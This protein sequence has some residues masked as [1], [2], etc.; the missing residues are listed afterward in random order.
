M[1]K[2]KARAD[3]T[4]LEY[5]YG[6]T[7]AFIVKYEEATYEKWHFHDF[8]EIQY[9]S[10]GHGF[11]LIGD[12]KIEVKAGDVFLT[13]FG[14]NH[15]FVSCDAREPL[16]LTNC[17]FRRE[18]FEELPLNLEDFTELG[19]DI[20]YTFAFKDDTEVSS[21][22][23]V[24]DKDLRIRKLLELMEAENAMQDSGFQDMLRLYLSELI[25]LFLRL[26]KEQSKENASIDAQREYIGEVLEYIK[27]NYT[28]KISLKQLAAI[29][30]ISPNHLCS[31]FKNMTGKTVSEYIQEMRLQN[32]CR[33]LRETDVSF[34]KIANE[35]GYEGRNFLQKLFIKTYGMTPGEYR[36]NVREKQD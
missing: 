36:K 22:I 30:T 24:Y 33:M 23:R 5:I 6:D 32:I 26:H 2:G 9:V 31:V 14:V 20:L 27:Y 29:A 35:N 18:T 16:V 25:I 13:S 1:N 21:Y 19:S 11:H 15:C 12:E 10:Q 8:W 4:K 17:V 3:V 28:Q 34:E 7:P